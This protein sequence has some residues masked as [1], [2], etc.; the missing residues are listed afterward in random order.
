MTALHRAAAEARV[1]DAE[2]W[3]VLAWQPPGG[4]IGSRN[5]CGPSDPAE[6][7]AAAV[8]RL[9]DVLATAFGT[10]GPGVALAGP[11]V[12]RSWAS[13]TRRSQ[14]VSGR[15]SLREAASAEDG[16]TSSA[17]RPASGPTSRVVL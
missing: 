14:S 5:G 1:R 13:T 6:H 15:R 17:N 12:R 16:A 8:E 2:L 9:R 4:E 7:R 3:A 10:A 11:P